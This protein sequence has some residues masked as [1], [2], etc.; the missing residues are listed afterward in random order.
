MKYFFAGLILMIFSTSNI[1]LFA[2]EGYYT[3]KTIGQHD[4]EVLGVF[5]NWNNTMFA[6]CSVDETVKLWSLP[7]GKLIR[8]MV[9][10]LGEVNNVS[11]SGND[12]YLATGSTDHTI[13]IWDVATGK[14]L[15]T[16]FGH[17]DQV[18][19]V[20]FSQD[21]ASTFVA[22]TSFDKTVKL[23]DVALGK[24]IKTLRG[25]T[26]TINNVAYS[27][28][29]L[30]IASCSD[31]KTIKIWSTDLSSKEPVKTLTGH[32]A[33][34]LTCVYSF[35]SKKMVSS[36]QSGQ[37]IIWAMPE[38]TILRKIQ[39]HNDLVQDVSFA[40]DNST[41][42]TGSLDKTV[43]LWNSNNGENLMVYFLGSEVWSVD[44]V[45]SAEIVTVGC[46]DGTIRLITKVDPAKMQIDS[47]QKK[48]TKKKK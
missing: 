10:H 1:S 14:E 26:A 32:D 37:V 28:D 30:H 41:I 40:E 18:I 16:L 33:P 6:S 17:T 43:K 29:G 36:D 7:D 27:Y 15:K 3:M 4:D 34:V 25:H 35:D 38:G 31:D 23:W 44:L 12:K 5:V 2:N 13:K 22:S 24:E 11:F 39:A 42:V 45:S 47:K 21:A 9:G 46:A 48:D 19:G 8:T 20:Y